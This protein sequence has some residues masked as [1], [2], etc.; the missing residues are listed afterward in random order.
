MLLPYF[1][2][3]RR[4]KMKIKRSIRTVLA[5]CSACLLSAGIIC[6][7]ADR[8]AYLSDVSMEN[9]FIRLSVEQD[10]SQGEY[11]RYRLDTTGGKTNNDDDDQKNITYRNFYSGYTTLNINGTEYVYGRGEDAGE[12]KFDADSRCHTSVQKFGDVTVEQ[13]LSFAEVY[14]PDY[15]DMLKI[16][17]RIL[18]AG[19][20]DR[21]G[22]RILIDPMLSDDDSATLSVKNTS[23][24][25]EAVFSQDMPENWKVQMRNNSKVAAYGKITSDSQTPDSVTF[26]DWS[27]LYDAVW[28]YSPD[29]EAPVSDT[30]VAVKWEPVTSVS[31][32]EFVT[33]YGIRN[34]VSTGSD[35]TAKIIKSPKTSDT[36]PLRSIALLG[37]AAASVAGYL[38]IRRKESRNEA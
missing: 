25:N 23:V 1:F 37:S 27:R 31:G 4:N 33:Y 35:N 36:F 12:P 34:D 10:K 9:S 18:D 30:A 8:T 20:N 11:L 24:K 3:E 26:A 22:V 2:I 19:Q 17:Y 28:G 14:T 5:A 38:I 13:K 7:A 32:K 15:E 29:I 21:I 16:S 6:F